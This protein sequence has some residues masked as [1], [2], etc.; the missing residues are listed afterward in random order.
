[1]LNAAYAGAGALKVGS[2]YVI[3]AEEGAGNCPL[4]V[5]SSDTHWI[6]PA[7]ITPL[8][9]ILAPRA[10]ADDPVAYFKTL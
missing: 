10:S 5:T 6:N 1:T 3:F 4:K 7:G 8:G 2:S 9:V